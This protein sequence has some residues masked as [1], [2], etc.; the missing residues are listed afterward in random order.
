MQLPS[1]CLETSKYCSYD[2]RWS[3]FQDQV[4]KKAEIIKRREISIKIHQF[5]IKLNVAA[6]LIL[7]PQIKLEASLASWS[8]PHRDEGLKLAFSSKEWQESHLSPT[9]KPKPVTWA[10]H[11]VS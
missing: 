5:P 7:L 1:Q 9:P 2:I 10:A 4:R 3:N 6:H 8:S 11:T